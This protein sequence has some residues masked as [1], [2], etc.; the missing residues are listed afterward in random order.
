MAYPMAFLFR[1]PCFQ[2]FSTERK[3]KL[4]RLS[5]HKQ[6]GQKFYKLSPKGRYARS[7]TLKQQHQG[8]YTKAAT[9]GQLHQVSYTRLAMLGLYT[10]S[11]C[12]VSKTNQKSSINIFKM[13]PSRCFQ[14]PE[15][16]PQEE[17]TLSKTKFW[18]FLTIFGP[19][20]HTYR[21]ILLTQP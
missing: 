7:A 9:Q 17:R 12:F 20:V 15:L 2:V 4:S 1:R 10:I 16:S 21:S 3:R 6:C 13:S 14:I 5:P 18:L 8:S 11:V 19:I